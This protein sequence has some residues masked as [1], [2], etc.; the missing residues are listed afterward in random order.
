M[1]N[2][3][4][5]YINPIINYPQNQHK[6]VLLNH[7]YWVTNLAIA[8]QR[9]RGIHHPAGFSA[10]T[11]FF[12]I[13]SPR[14]VCSQWLPKNMPNMYI[15]ILYRD[16]HC[17]S[18]NIFYVLTSNIQVHGRCAGGSYGTNLEGR[19][20]Q[21][22]MSWAFQIGQKPRVG[23]LFSHNFARYWVFFHGIFR[24]PRM[25]VPLFP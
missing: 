14:L 11:F 8:Q 1:F 20:V 4:Y 21:A 17:I 2:E 24:A 18:V 3:V 10:G 12:L 25:M 13:F 5:I 23:N 15:Y 22:R 7:P 6:W 16:T 9:H 19:Q